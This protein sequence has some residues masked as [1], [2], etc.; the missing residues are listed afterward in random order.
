MLTWPLRGEVDDHVVML[1]DARMVEELPPSI[2][3]HAL[4]NPHNDG[5]IS[6]DNGPAI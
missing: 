3:N 6:N 5:D 4:G 2:V 1:D